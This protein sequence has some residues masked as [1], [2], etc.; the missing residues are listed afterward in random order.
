MRREFPAALR[1]TGSVDDWNAQVIAEFRANGGRVGGN[2]ERAPMA[3]LHHRGRKSGRETVT[4]ILY[5]PD[6][7]DDATVYV[8]ASNAGAHRTHTLRCPGPR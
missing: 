3:L 4:P 8:F 6:P 1:H 5:P 7:D 2:F